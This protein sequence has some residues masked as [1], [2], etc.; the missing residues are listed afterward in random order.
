MYIINETEKEY[1]NGTSGPK[2]LMKGMRMNFGV[3][4]LQP[5]ES[6]SPHY[7][8]VMEENFFVAEGEAEIKVNDKIYPLKT[9]DFVHC[10]PSERHALGN[11]GEKPARIFFMMSPYMDADKV[12][13][14]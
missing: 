5:G 3:I 11:P 8:Q 13:C 4:L 9:G 10:E 12:E 14:E 1:R 2:Y 7:H 6:M